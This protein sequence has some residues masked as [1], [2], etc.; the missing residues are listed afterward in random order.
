MGIQDYVGHTVKL[1]GYLSASAA[2][3]GVRHSTVDP[4][5]ARCAMRL[6]GSDTNYGFRSDDLAYPVFPTLT[7]P[8]THLPSVPHVLLLYRFIIQLLALAACLGCL[9]ACRFR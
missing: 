7:L 2:A 3:G 1:G 5:T 9:N 8:D 4:S 6:R